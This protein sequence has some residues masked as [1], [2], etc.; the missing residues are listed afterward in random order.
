LLDECQ[1]EGTVDPKELGKGVSAG[2][3]PKLVAAVTNL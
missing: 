2:T 1:N 3:D